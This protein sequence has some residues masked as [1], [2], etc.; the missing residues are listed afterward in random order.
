MRTTKGRYEKLSVTDYEGAVEKLTSQLE[1]RGYFNGSLDYIDPTPREISLKLDL[2]RVFRCFFGDE[3]KGEKHF[4]VAFLE[5]YWG[6]LDSP[7]DYLF[8]QKPY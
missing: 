8:Y 6:E 1:K 5:Y 3:F 2:P 4:T 7:L